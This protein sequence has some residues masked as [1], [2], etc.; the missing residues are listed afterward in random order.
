MC[1]VLR[2]DV[3]ACFYAIDKFIT[4]YFSFLLVFRQRISMH[5]FVCGV[6][7]IGGG[8]QG[9]IQG[10]FPGFPEPT[11]PPPPPPQPKKREEKKVKM[12]T[13]MTFSCAWKPPLSLPQTP[14]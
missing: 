9:R 5:A 2:G 1:L 10:G 12:N 7:N 14:S 13:L 11:P 8:L 3:G 6:V 4:F